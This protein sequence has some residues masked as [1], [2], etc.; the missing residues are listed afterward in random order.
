MSR[1]IKFL[2]LL[3]VLQA[4]LVAWVHLEGDAPDPFKADTPLVAVDVDS[5]DTVTIEQPGERLLRLTRKGDGW[6]LPHKSDFPVLSAKFEQ[7]TDKLLGAR[8]SWPVGQTMVAARQ[9][10]VTMDAFERRV[11]FLEGEAV[12]GDVFLGSS[13][14]FRKVHARLD[15]DEHTYAV[16]F[17]AFDAPVDPSQWYDTEALKTPVNDI[18]RIDLGA[19]A[20]KAKDGGFQ[21]E[22]LRENEQTDVE[23][24]QEM[25][26]R[27]SEVTFTD[28][29]GDGGRARFEAGKPVVRYTIELKEGTPVE[30]IV[31]APDESNRYIL[32]SSAQPYYFEVE[33]D[34]FDKLRDTSRVQAVKGVDA[35]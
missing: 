5:A 22:D 31:V 7:F 13:P 20:L 4:G 33:K 16:D 25:V 11:R 14:G 35:G 17:N 27:V 21:V 8:R 3:L 30:H 12:L 9:F 6:V 10:K 23:P 19:F 24:V 34:P 26:E 2:L 15:G 18:A 32:K 29:L 28:V 1:S